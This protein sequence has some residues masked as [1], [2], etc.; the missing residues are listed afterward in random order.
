M[1]LSG[2]AGTILVATRSQELMTH[3]RY[4]RVGDREG[5]GPFFGG[6]LLDTFLVLAK[7]D[8]VT[9]RRGPVP[10]PSQWQTGPLLGVDPSLS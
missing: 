4:L 8:H 10:H 5:T 2:I 6:P 9:L 3:L 7:T 1:G